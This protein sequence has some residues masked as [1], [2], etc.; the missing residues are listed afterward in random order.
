MKR[1]ILVIGACGQVGTELVLELRAMHGESLI[2]AS[3]IRQ[4]EN[5]ELKSGP[6]EILNVLEKNA[7]FE[8]VKRHDIGT[9]YNMAALLSATA[10]KNPEFGWELNMKG[11]FHVLDLARE[12]H[13]EK[14]F[15]PSSIAVFGP[16]TPKKKTPQDCIMDPATVYGISKL[17]GER[18]CEYYAKRWDVD[19]RSVR[20][21]GLISYKAMPG[22]GTT[23]YAVEIFH[24]ALK[25]GNYTSF[26]EKDT[27]LPMLY[28]PDA[29][30]ATIGV[31]ECEGHLVKIRSSYN[32]AGFSFSPKELA[33]EITKQIPSFSINYEPDFRQ[34]IA[35][36]WPGSIDDSVARKDWGWKN[37]YGLNEMVRDMLE[38]LKK[39]FAIA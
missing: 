31:T 9:I 36:G 27:E 32:L 3:D 15:W 16:T 37:D 39:Q 35:E 33:D 6:F 23:D 8:V 38:N 7:L 14:T 19:V 13:I 11:L 2:I 30:K 17:A 25:D 28:M 29:I 24:K 22:G 20:Y 34:K 21:P 5:E 18:W 26:L 1:K 10:E 12:K 4:P